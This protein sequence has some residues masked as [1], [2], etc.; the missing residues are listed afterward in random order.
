L[1]RNKDN[2]DNNKKQGKIELPMPWKMDRWKYY[3]VT[4]K[5]HVVCNPMSVAKLDEL[6]E[7][8]ALNPGATVL[9]IACGLGEML[10]RLAERYG[11]SG[12]GVDLSPYCVADAQQKLKERVPEAG[13]E[14]LNIDGAAYKSDRL[15]DLTMCIGA[16]WVYQGHRGSL[17]ALKAMTR[18]G[19]LVLVGEPF[20]LREPE[21]AFL[22]AEN[23]TRD[24]FG[25]HYENV[26]V[27][28]EEGLVPLFTMVSNQDDWDGYEALQ[29]HTTEKYAR[30]NPDDPDLSEIM[31]RVAHN[32]TSYLR[33]GR[34]TLGWALYLFRKEGRHNGVQEYINRNRPFQ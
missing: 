28:E 8:L 5:R 26:L 32:R 19:G 14:I 16:S 13:I 24:M 18:P 27:G 31:L 29:W 3:N 15:F 6:I 9:D 30:E 1:V 11:V 25:T 12:V 21:E 34:D 23:H 17:R 7:L 20:W 2:S 22:V 33:W 4:H 10:T